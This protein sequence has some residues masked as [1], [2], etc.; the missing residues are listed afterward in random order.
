MSEE[1]QLIKNQ[2]TDEQKALIK[3][4]ICEGATDDEIKLFLHLCNKLQLD[5]FCRQIFLIERRS[6]VNGKWIPRKIPMISIDGM[7]LVADRSGQYSGQLGPFWAD[8]NGKWFDLWT[9]DIPPFAAKIG[10]LKTNFSEPL[11]SIAEWKSY[12]QYNS[13][14]KLNKFWGQFSTLM[15][16]KCAEALGLR[17]CF[18]DLSGLYI[19]EEI[20]DSPIIESKSFEKDKILKLKESEPKEVKKPSAKKNNDLMITFG[21]FKGNL[22][23]EIKINDLKGLYKFLKDSSK[24]STPTQEKLNFMAS[25]DSFIREAE[26]TIK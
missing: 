6:Q 19:P 12:A 3:A 10:I 15:L 8:K 5:P 13:D 16:A 9:Q 2:I 24:G 7:R 4:Q 20:N 18:P 1:N 11:W 26:K 25:L 23:S 22:F 21:T 14:K 17:K